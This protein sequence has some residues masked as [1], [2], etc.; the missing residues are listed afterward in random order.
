MRI[1]VFGLAEYAASSECGVNPRF[2][3]PHP[4]DK[5]YVRRGSKLEIFR[6][7]V[8]LRQP[9]FCADIQAALLDPDDDTPIAPSVFRCYDFLPDRWILAPKSTT[10]L[11]D[12]KFEISQGAF[13]AACTI[14]VIGEPAGAKT[15]CPIGDSGVG[16]GT[17]GRFN[18]V[19][20]GLL[21]GL[22]TGKG[23]KGSGSLLHEGLNASYEYVTT[24][25]GSSFTDGAGTFSEATVAQ[26]LTDI[27]GVAPGAAHS[28]LVANDLNSYATSSQAARAA[29]IAA[30]LAS[31]DLF[32]AT[33]SAVMPSTLIVVA[34]GWPGHIKNQGW[35][36]TY[37]FQRLQ[38]RTIWHEWREA[39]FVHFTDRLA[40]NI[41]IDPTGFEID[42]R[43]FPDTDGHHFHESNQPG[44]HD[45]IGR[46]RSNALAGFWSLIP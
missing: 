15:W 41:V 8:Q 38:W 7:N 26:W 18:A 44:G 14:C 32:F 11:G 31:A 45:I 2:V 25:A 17:S 39:F 34:D 3:L 9:T 6:D 5:I 27:G 33:F 21:G 30:T 23:T 10:P 20:Q 4:R 19:A 42:P 43:A 28:T 40:E 16:N 1:P 35:V 24:N 29:R 46:G 37:G 36:D 12:Y 13:S 22:L